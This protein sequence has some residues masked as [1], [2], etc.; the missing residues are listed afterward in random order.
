MLTTKPSLALR[1][2]AS[3]L[4]LSSSQVNAAISGLAT[5]GLDIGGDKIET[6]NY[7]NSSSEDINAGA[8]FSIGVGVIFH[9][10]LAAG[11]ETQFTFNWKSD[12]TTAS[13]GDLSFDRYP[14]ELIQFYRLNKMRAGAGISYHVNPTLNGSGFAA[15]R[16]TSYDNA[17]GYVFEMDYDI[18]PTIYLGGRVT[19]IEYQNSQQPERRYDGHSLGFGAGIRF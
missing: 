18:T 15:K 1:I 2:L 11:P 8:L 13:N 10:Q 7:T 4:C 16:Q 9:T 12:F 3:G 14:I 17:L 5:L 6:V 19:I